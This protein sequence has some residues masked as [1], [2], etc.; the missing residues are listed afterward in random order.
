MAVLNINR[1]TTYCNAIGRGVITRD[2]AQSVRLENQKMGRLIAELMAQYADL[3]Y[4]DQAGNVLR[5]M[6][7]SKARVSY[8]VS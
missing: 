7:G 4:L 6:G 3:Q 5:C 1:A 2:R 8:F